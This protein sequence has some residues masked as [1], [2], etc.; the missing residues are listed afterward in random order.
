MQMQKIQKEEEEMQKKCNLQGKNGARDKKKPFKI[1]Q[2]FS[3]APATPFHFKAYVRRPVYKT[4][5]KKPG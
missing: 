4:T 1:V 5:Q 2:K 3:P